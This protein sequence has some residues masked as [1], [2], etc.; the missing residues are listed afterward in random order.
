MKLTQFVLALAAIGLVL[1]P[2]WPAAL[3]PLALIWLSFANGSK[4]RLTAR[5]M[6][7]RAVRVYAEPKRGRR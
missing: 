7:R 1:S 5:Q 3:I 4:P 2:V 6:R